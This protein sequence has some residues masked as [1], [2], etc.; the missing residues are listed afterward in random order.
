MIEISPTLTFTFESFGNWLCCT[1]AVCGKHNAT[2]SIKNKCTFTDILHNKLTSPGKFEIVAV[3]QSILHVLVENDLDGKTLLHTTL[4]I[5]TAHVM[6]KAHAVQ[7]SHD[8]ITPET[9]IIIA[10]K[11]IFQNL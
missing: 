9:T 3:C 4:I 8:G 1:H 10:F 6:Q 2:V 7:C 5:C 11:H